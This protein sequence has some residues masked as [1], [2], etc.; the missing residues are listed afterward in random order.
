MYYPDDLTACT[1]IM[2]GIYDQI[3][4]ELR[5]RYLLAYQSSTEEGDD[6]FRTVEVKVR[7]DGLEA[8]TIRGYYP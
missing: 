8:R 5:S 7:G 2:F 6:A 3:L 1:P 4:Q